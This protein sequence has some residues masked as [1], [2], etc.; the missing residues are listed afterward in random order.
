MLK[1]EDYNVIMPS[2]CRFGGQDFLV[3]FSVLGMRPLS[4]LSPQQLE[5]YGCKEIEA[6]SAF[7]G[8]QQTSTW[9]EDGEKLTKT[10]PPLIDSDKTMQELQLVKK[11]VIAEQYPRDSMHQLWALIV[12]YHPEF[13]NL[14]I[15]SKLALTSSVHTAG[16]ERGFSVQNRILTTFRNRL[17]IDTQH[18]LM[19]V[20]LDPHNRNSFNFD[21][22]ITKWK[23]AK[24]RRI[25]ELN[26]KDKKHRYTVV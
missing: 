5:E 2:F 8:S 21:L 26:L 17:T 3:N 7:Y 20:K 13:P 15:L 18:R 25:Y 6:L 22:A 14:T 1:L 11:V 4:F 10:S 16:C 24:E 23:N 9:L 12:K 19:M